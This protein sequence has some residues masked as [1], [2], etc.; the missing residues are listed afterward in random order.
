MAVFKGDSYLGEA[1]LSGEVI[2]LNIQFIKRYLATSPDPVNYTGTL[3]ESEDF[4]HGKW[5]LGRFASG[6]WSARSG[7]EN[8]IADLKA[9]LSYWVPV[10]ASRL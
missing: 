1:K 6:P 8:L 5:C 10:P 2:G 4:L 9:R 7:G 3:A